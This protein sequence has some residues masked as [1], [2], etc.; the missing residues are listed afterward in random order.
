[1]S[2]DALD[3]AFLAAY[4]AIADDMFK[5]DPRG[6]E[7][8]ALRETARVMRAARV[9]GFDD[10]LAKERVIALI[11][12]LDQRD[13]PEDLRKKHPAYLRELAS[14]ACDKEDVRLRNAIRDDAMEQAF[15][16]YSDAANSRARMRVALAGMRSHGAVAS[17][18]TRLDT[19]HRAYERM[20]A[21]M[22]WHKQPD[23]DEGT[24]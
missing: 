22:K 13:K 24:N 17:L 10:D 9:D 18:E 4:Q 8:E 15:A 11:V 6:R 16:R 21:A 5:S 19:E 23:D 14:S 1:M 12:R 7:I 2:N 3:P 20:E